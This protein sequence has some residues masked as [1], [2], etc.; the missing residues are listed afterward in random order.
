MWDTAGQERYKSITAAY[1]KG[2]KGALIVY[3]TTQK[4]SFENIDK[5][6]A[7][8]K[9]KSSK[10]MKLMIVGN[11]TDLKDERQVT[12]EEALV[13]AKD[14]EAPIMEASAL[15]GSNVK[16]AFYDLLK[17]MYKEIRKKLDIVESQ[18]ESG[19]DAVQLDTTEE[20]KKKG[21]C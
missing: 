17:E 20:K 11:K 9:D 16:E 1:Y 21:C 13:K 8:I 3:D 2:A 7:E 15:D 14:L 5:W 6:M 18:A 4:T 12:T 19:K 10:D